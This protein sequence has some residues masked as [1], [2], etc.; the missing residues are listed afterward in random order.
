MLQ[1]VYE[2]AVR[3]PHLDR[4][5]IA[6]DSEEVAGLCR[7]QGWPF[8][9]TSSE[10][11]SGSDRVQAVAAEV[12]ADIYV[13]IQGDEPLLQPKHISALLRP[14][15]QPHVHVSTLRVACAAE[16]ISNPNAV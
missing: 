5:I 14:F 4:I 9:I 16:D 12:A 13:N 7:D 15:R 8:R 6:T 11:A 3:C 1:W 10:L 2:A